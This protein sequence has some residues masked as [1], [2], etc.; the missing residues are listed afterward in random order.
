MITA[1]LYIPELQA[2]VG[3]MDAY[4]LMYDLDFQ[5]AVGEVVSSNCKVSIY[6][7]IYVYDPEYVEQIKLDFVNRVKC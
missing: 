2:E 5:Q 3:G 7:T 4:D 6:E 1:K